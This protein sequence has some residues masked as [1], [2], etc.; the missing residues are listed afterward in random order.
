M[1][2]EK[3]TLIEKVMRK[4]EEERKREGEKLRVKRVEK[5]VGGEQDRREWTT[6]ER[7]KE[8]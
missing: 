1:K 8:R 4:T 6:I 7:A 3:A 5:G 2:K